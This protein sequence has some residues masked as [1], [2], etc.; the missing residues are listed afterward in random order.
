MMVERAPGGEWVTGEEGLGA[1]ALL[2]VE[3]QLLEA[4]RSLTASHH[5]TVG[6]DREHLPRDPQLAGLGH[7]ASA[8]HLEPL[9]IERVKAPGH[10]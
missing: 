6:G 9:A 5:D 8:M 3:L 10:G 1:D 2:A 7:Q 4:Q